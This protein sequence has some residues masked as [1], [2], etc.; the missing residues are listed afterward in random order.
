MKKPSRWLALLL[1][2]VAFLELVAHVH[3]ASTAPEPAVYALLKEPIERLWRPGD[4]L[5]VAPR[6]A[7]PLVRA[8]LDE[9]ELQIAR[10]AGPDLSGVQRALE[11]SVLSELDPETSGWRVAHQESIGPFELRVRQNPS[12]EP[13]YFDFV[14]AAAE[15]RARVYVAGQQARHQCR[16]VSDAP[17]RTGGLHG[18]L[19]LP[20]HRFDCDHG[21]YAAVSVI[22]DQDYLPRRCVMVSAPR[23][24]ALVIAFEA[25]REGS[26]IVG[27]VGS[28]FF[29]RRADP[30][31]SGSVVVRVNERRVGRVDHQGR[32]GWT[33]FAFSVGSMRGSVEFRATAGASSPSNTFCFQAEVR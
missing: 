26:K 2:L 13:V 28:S 8:A 23:N 29:L 21:Y 24:G 1:P 27:H 22:D 10:V 31:R 32:L 6:W 3:Y 12:A 5:V 18:P 14:A 11:I 33:P 17:R 7:E 30:G 25:P 20:A 19:A 15:G 4:A 16:W 9:R